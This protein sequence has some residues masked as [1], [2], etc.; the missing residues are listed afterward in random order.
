MGLLYLVSWVLKWRVGVLSFT[1]STTSGV[2]LPFAKFF[3]FDQPANDSELRLSVYAAQFPSP[4]ASRDLDRDS[5]TLVQHLRACSSRLV[6]SDASVIGKWRATWGLA[7]ACG[8]TFHGLYRDLDVCSCAA[9]V[10]AACIVAK[11]S[12]LLDIQLDLLTDSM[13]VLRL[14]ERFFSHVSIR[15]RGGC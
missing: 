9:E 10:Y 3:D 13:F 5:I 6:A 4:M 2:A 11:V 8:T 14:W 12:N 15:H 7:C 1:F